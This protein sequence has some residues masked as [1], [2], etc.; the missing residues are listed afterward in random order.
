MKAENF[1]VGWRIK[2]TIGLV[3]SLAFFKGRSSLRGGRGLPGPPLSPTPH[4]KRDWH[5]RS[6][7]LRSSGAF[8]VLLIISKKLRILIQKT[9]IY[10]SI[11]FIGLIFVWFFNY[12]V[13]SIFLI[14]ILKYIIFYSNTYHIFYC[15]KI[16][17]ELI[18][19]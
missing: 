7:N 18:P 9:S 12:G 6:S 11:Y 8:V 1:N 17:D 13:S 5:D 3:L 16:M 15:F 19:P 2:G 10:F 4:R 14:N